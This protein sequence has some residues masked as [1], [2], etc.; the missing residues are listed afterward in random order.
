MGDL[1]SL[2]P[3]VGAWYEQHGT[4]VQRVR[5]Q[6]T[7]DFQKCIS[8]VKDWEKDNGRDECDLIAL[9]ALGGRLDQTLSNIHVLH[10][11]LKDTEEQQPASVMRRRPRKVHLVSN[12]SIA[13]LLYPG[14]KHIIKCHTDI[15]GPTC[16]VLPIGVPV[17]RVVTKGLKW[18]LDETMPSSFGTLVSTSN[19]FGENQDTEADG[20]S[21]TVTVQTD[22]PVIW[23]TEV[24]MA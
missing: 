20:D 11:I 9:G 21:H 19:A 23:T 8:R 13:V 3:E 14:V 22:A 16:G 4:T 24:H 5:D 10:R 6:D 15:E 18:D 17:A 7:T 2:R 12:E 1:D